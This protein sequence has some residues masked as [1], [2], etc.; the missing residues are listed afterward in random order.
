MK[1]SRSLELLRLLVSNS[2][3]RTGVEKRFW[4]HVEKTSTCWNWTGTLN[5]KG[6]YA[7][8]PILR[9][10]IVASRVA[11]VLHSGCVP[12]HDICHTC[13]NPRCVNPEHL[14]DGT[15]QDN[16]NDMVKKGRQARWEGA[17]NSV[18]TIEQVRQIRAEYQKGKP[19]FSTVALGKKHGIA[20]TNI[21]QIV[22]GKA[23]R[24]I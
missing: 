14:F 2:N 3:L 7:M 22:A 8:Y 4:T 1:P 10:N 6:G 23:W 16:A 9:H 19:G 24:G 13:D 12:S 15:E 17:G 21:W 11:W 5:Q 20:P 18:L